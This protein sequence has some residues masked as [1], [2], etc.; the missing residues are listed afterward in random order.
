MVREKYAVFT[1]LPFRPLLDYFGPDTIAAPN[2]RVAIDPSATFAASDK[3]VS[4]TALQVP[5][6]LS[7]ASL[8][9]GDASLA[10]ARSGETLKF[11]RMRYLQTSHCWIKMFGFGRGSPIARAY[12]R[13]TRR[14]PLS[15]DRRKLCS[16]RGHRRVANAVLV[17]KRYAPQEIGRR[18]GRGS[19]Q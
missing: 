6:R 1:V 19:E 10:G 3:S 17:D 12:A 14:H 18:P 15:S 4:D 2:A 9:A 7:T 5:L 8:F 13:H 11:L 16:R